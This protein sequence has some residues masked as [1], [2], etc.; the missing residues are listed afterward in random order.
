[1]HTLIYASTATAK[2]S[3]EEMNPLLEKAKSYTTE[4]GISG[5]LIYCTVDLVQILEGVKVIIETL[6]AKIRVDER[7]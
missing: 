1:M 5:S 6:Y 7:T 3:G 4:N 2:I